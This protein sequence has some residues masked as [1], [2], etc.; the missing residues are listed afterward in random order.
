[1]QNIK[2]YLSYDPETGIFTWIKKPKYS[3]IEIGFIA[4]YQTHTHHIRIKYNRKLY[5][6]HRL[7]WFFTYGVVPEFNID[8][9]NENPSDNRICNLRLDSNKENE[10]NV[11]TPQANNKSGYRGVCWATKERK[12]VASIKL[13]GKTTRIGRY[14]TPEEAHAAYLC[15]KREL[16][17]F[18]VE[19]KD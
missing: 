14:D 12:W 19:D 1:M 8:H 2:E 5:Q 7:A 17:P 13:K 11:S 10:Q 16:H 3:R 18:W 6:A 9:I 4:G 15:A